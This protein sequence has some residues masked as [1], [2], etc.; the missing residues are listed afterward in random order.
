MG[1]FTLMSGVLPF[2]AMRFVARREEGAT[3]TG[4]F[5]N[6]IIALLAA[7]VYIP[8][9]PLIT[10]A[11][12]ISRQYVFL[13]Y[14]VA[15]QIIE[16]YLISG[17]ENC[18]T[19]IKPHVLGYGL[20]TAEFS[21]ISL[22]YILM[23][24]LHHPLEGALVSIIVGLLVQSIYYT[25]LLAKEFQ[26]RVRWSYVKEWLKGSLVNIYNIIGN[27]IASYIFIML[28]VIGGNT[29]RS[30]YGAASLIAGMI[31]Y[32]SYLTIAL[33]P[34]LLA[35]RNHKDITTSIKM[36]LMF[37]IPMTIGVIA[38]PGAYLAILS[39][40]Y[41]VATPVLIVLAVDA[42]VATLSGFFSDVLYGAERVDEKAKMSFK[43][44][45]KSR[46]FLSFSFPYI[47]FAITLPTAY[48]L[49][50]FYARN[51]PLRAA[52]YVSV[53]NSAGH[54]ILFLVLYA[55]VRKMITINIP[56]KS[57]AKYT[58][59][60]TIMGIILYVLPHPTRVYMTVG[61]TAIGGIVYLVLLM[62]IDK[63]ARTLIRSVLQGIKIR[64]S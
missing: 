19:S 55:V 47:H 23:V 28:F 16:L 37:T 33:Y 11:L 24:Q 57:I 54:F 1:Y 63:E 60:A 36:M 43:E 62:A 22:G 46:L 41:T 6:L 9:V 25:K 58:F 30:N 59:S 13:Y 29:A 10:S 52:L 5:T 38:L 8:L 12:S 4:V 61:V 18:L 45:V 27:Q 44:L 26:Q 15:L 17:F 53:I 48:Y 35:D 50:T 49:L 20:L 42:L 31:T 14:L 40:A 51:H 64:F 2:W 34:K 21:K 3:K 56:W 39:P 32:S 7:A